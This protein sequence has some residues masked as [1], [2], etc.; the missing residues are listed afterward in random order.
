[1]AWF[2]TSEFGVSVEHPRGD[3]WWIFP[4]KPVQFRKGAQTEATSLRGTNVVVKMRE[5]VDRG[6]LSE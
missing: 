3:G 5:T 4:Q 2:G 6:E 1:M